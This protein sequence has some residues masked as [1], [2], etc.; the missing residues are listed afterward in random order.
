MLSR[1]FLLLLACGFLGTTFYYLRPISNQNQIEIKRYP[2]DPKYFTEN[3]YQAI[4]T[5]KNAVP[6]SVKAAYIE[7]F[8]DWYFCS[9]LLRIVPFRTAFIEED[10]LKENAARSKMT[11]FLDDHPEAIVYLI[12]AM[13]L[14]GWEHIIFQELRGGSFA[15][16][17]P[18]FDPFSNQ[19]CA[20]SWLTTST[21]FN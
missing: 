5:A 6:E 7:L 8:R 21:R 19:I 18:E 15:N 11:E 2:G 20:K 9:Q 1:F 10:T 12:E 3:E 13:L 14:P 16:C 4:E 17:G